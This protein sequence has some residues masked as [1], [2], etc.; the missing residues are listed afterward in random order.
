[1]VL[2]RPANLWRVGCIEVTYTMRRMRL[3]LEEEKK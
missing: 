3:D 2:R 1:M